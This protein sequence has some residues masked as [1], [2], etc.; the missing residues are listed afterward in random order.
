MKF[1]LLLP[2]FNVGA[3]IGDII[4]QAK[5]QTKPF[6]EILAYDDAS[7]DDT[8]AVL[9]SKGVAVIRGPTNSGSAFARNALLAAS[10]SEYVHFHDADDPF[11]SAH[12]VE[13]LASLCGP[14]RAAFCLTRFDE[15]S[16]ATNFHPTNPPRLN[17]DWGRY[18]IN[19]HAHLNSTIFPREALQRI[20]GFANELR[21][22]QDLMLFIML[23]N[24]GVE[25]EFLPEVLAVHKK[26]P[27][28]TLQKKA[29]FEHHVQS[30]RMC[31][32]A[33]NRV[34]AELRPEVL[35]RAGFHLRHLASSGH[36]DAA[37]QALH[38]LGNAWK[39]M[40]KSGGNLEHTICGVFGP[41]SWLS[42]I[43]FRST[44]GPQ[45][46]ASKK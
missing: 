8:V 11:E 14:N 35:G 1:G 40:P 29:A 32:L 39:E 26:R 21:T 5:R 7:E 20:G 25:F 37:K 36:L 2:C 4:E 10:T 12:F 31:A 15:L 27:D 19:H 41:E 16:G 6:D 30:V 34:R 33:A 43:A 9:Q 45:R 28:S 23:G 44:R 13:S 17:Q 24:A 42:Y 22:Q 18:F 38:L 3:Y 46:H